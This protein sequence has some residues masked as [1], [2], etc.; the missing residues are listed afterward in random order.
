MS[1]SHSLPCLSIFLCVLS[2]YYYSVNIFL[3]FSFSLSVYH[4]FSLFHTLSIILSVYLSIIL[5]LSFSLSLSLSLSFSYFQIKIAWSLNVSFC[6][7]YIS[8][9]RKRSSMTIHSGSHCF[10]WCRCSWFSELVCTC[11]GF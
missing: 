7:S 5:F 9:Y 2:C 6:V 11:L 4:S 8:M 1:L 3:F 10:T